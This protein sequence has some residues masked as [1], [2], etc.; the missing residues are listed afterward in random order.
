M[1]NHVRVFDDTIQVGNATAKGL[2]TR[3]MSDLVHACALV[4]RQ[5]REHTT[6]EIVIDPVIT[7]ALIHI[8][9]TCDLANYW[10]VSFTI[11]DLNGYVD[12]AN[13]EPNELNE[14]IGALTIAATGI[15]GQDDSRIAVDAYVPESRCVAGGSEPRIDRDALL[16]LAD[17]LER[18]SAEL[19]QR[20]LDTPIELLPD[21]WS[22]VAQNSSAIA[23]RIREACGVTE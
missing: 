1:K 11:T 5:M 7:P 3:N 14:L 19:C 2:T 22:A 15:G 18:E 12:S 21:W 23:S 17:Q 8:V 10:E 6:N 16:A 20:I 9:A 13:L 4:A